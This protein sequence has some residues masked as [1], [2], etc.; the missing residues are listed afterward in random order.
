MKRTLRCGVTLIEVMIAVI[1]LSLLFASANSVMTYSRRETEKGFWIQQAITQLRNATRAIS[2]KMKQTSYPSTLIRT[3][4]G[5]EKVISFKEKREY[6]ASGRLRKLD[7]NPSDAYEMR[8]VISGSGALIPSFNEQMIMYFPVCEPERDYD[9]GYTPGK[10]TW[11]CL[12][13]K[14]AKDYRYTG[15]GS[16]HMIEHEEEY[17]TRSSVLKRAFGLNRTFEKS[18]PIVRDKELVTDVREIEVDF[19]DIDELKGVYVTKSG[20]RPDDVTVKRTLISMS[21][22]CC[23]PKD[24]KIWMSDQCSVINNV[25]LVEMPAPPAMK[26]VKVLSI[27]PGGS[28]QVMVNGAMQTVNVGSMLN[29]YKVKEIHVDALLLLDPATGNEWFLYRLDE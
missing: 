14:P 1:L 7:I 15:L 11:V 9:T 19:Y 13:L 2:M 26:L 18:I 24:R 8:S 5:D 3:A 28:A 6:D 22:A 29:S 4:T 21:I 25:E 16:L 17:D 12:V 10:I 27:G 20:E 23:H